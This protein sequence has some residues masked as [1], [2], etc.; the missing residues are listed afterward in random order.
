MSYDKKY[1][2]ISKADFRLWMEEPSLAR[3]AL[4]FCSIVRIQSFIV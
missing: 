1:A 2:L 3:K 4:A